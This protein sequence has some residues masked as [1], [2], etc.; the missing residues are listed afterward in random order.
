MAGAV[1]KR[2]GYSKIE[3]LDGHWAAWK[4]AELPQDN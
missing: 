2:R 3:Y 1:L 4:D